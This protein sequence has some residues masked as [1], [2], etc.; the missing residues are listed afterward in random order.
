MTRLLHLMFYSHTLL[1]RSRSRILGTPDNG[2]APAVGL[3]E[4]LVPRDDI[5]AGTVRLRVAA[6]VVSGFRVA[7][8]GIVRPEAARLVCREGSGDGAEAQEE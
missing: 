7:E 1:S 5:G 3:T 8:E 4:V 2:L 6:G